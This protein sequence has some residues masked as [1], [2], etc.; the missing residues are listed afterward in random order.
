MP[1]NLITKKTAKLMG[2]KADKPYGEIHKQLMKDAFDIAH[3]Y[4]LD[5]IDAFDFGKASNLKNALSKLDN[6]DRKEVEE[7]MEVIESELNSA[8]F[9]VQRALDFY[10]NEN[11][12]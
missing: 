11:K 1:K 12:I 10:L 2:I 4:F 5:D 3:E 8:R 7:F 9:N 6:I